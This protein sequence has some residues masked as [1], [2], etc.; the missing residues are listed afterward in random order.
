MT[1]IL[2]KC[3]INL[4]FVKHFFSDLHS[5]KPV[6]LVFSEVKYVYLKLIKAHLPDDLLP[7]LT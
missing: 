3:Q 4:S 1:L 2:Y 5:Y 6:Q 7:N